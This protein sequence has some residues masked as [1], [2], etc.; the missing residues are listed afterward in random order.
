MTPDELDGLTIDELIRRA[1]ASAQVFLRY[2][3]SCPGCL[4]SPFM[5]VDEAAGEYGVEPGT[6]KRDLLACFEP[7]EAFG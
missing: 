3:M 2:R 1:P 4:L 7:E 6:L 5:T